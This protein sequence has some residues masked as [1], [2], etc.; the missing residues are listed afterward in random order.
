[1]E[2]RARLVLPVLVPDALAMRF[3]LTPVPP[4][5]GGPSAIELEYGINGVELGRF[6]VPAESGVLTFRIEP[7]LLHRGDNI[8]ISIA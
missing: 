4:E 5:G 7:A 3:Q 6:V 2:R 8:S 1:V